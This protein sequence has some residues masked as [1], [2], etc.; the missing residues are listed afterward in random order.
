MHY[1]TSDGWN[2][3]NKYHIWWLKYSTHY[4]IICWILILTYFYSKVHMSYEV[5]VK[6]KVK[7]LQNFV[8]FSEYMNFKLFI[9]KYLP[10]FTFKP[11]ERQSLNCILTYDKKNQS[12]YTSF[13][14]ECVDPIVRNWHKLTIYYK[15]GLKCLKEHLFFF[16]CHCTAFTKKFHLAQANRVV[17]V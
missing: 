7:I 17:L 10:Y 15:N 14:Y 1:P 11:T 3:C 13:H 5:P 9:T 16:I 8:A 6:N 2:Y 12:C 4:W